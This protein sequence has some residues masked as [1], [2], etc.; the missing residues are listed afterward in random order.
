MK[1]SRKSAIILCIGYAVA[2][3]GASLARA[4]PMTGLSLAAP[5]V[6]ALERPV[7]D[8]HSHE[9]IHYRR[10]YHRHN[11]YRRHY[12]PRYRHRYYHRPA[13][14]YYRPRYYYPTYRYPRYYYR[15]Y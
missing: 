14:R 9:M 13:Y 12:Y 11:Y 4:T 10:Y 7:I 8:S 5:S 1:L 2:V 3:V 6:Q 15:S